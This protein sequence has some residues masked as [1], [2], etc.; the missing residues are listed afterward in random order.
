MCI[1]DSININYASDAPN[2]PNPY[3]DGLQP[4]DAF[5]D[6]HND[7][8]TLVNLQLGYEWDNYGIYFIGKNI[9]DEE[10]YVAHRARNAR[11]GA[12]AEYAISF[13][14]VFDW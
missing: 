14:G 2:R 5:F 6:L 10:Y 1:R 12:P 4:G 8:R 13:R 3:R 7:A 11:L 9:T